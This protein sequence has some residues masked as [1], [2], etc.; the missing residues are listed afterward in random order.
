MLFH[1]LTKNN[2]DN[3][4]GIGN[5]TCFFYTTGTVAATTTLVPA[6]TQTTVPNVSATCAPLRCVAPCDLGVTFGPDN[7]PVCKCRA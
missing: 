7:C 4:S 2:A 1:L 5:I 3:K 6:I